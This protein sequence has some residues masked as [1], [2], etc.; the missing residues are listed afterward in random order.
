[1]EFENVGIDI[2]TKISNKFNEDNNEG[3]PSTVTQ[4]LDHLDLDYK[5]ELYE[6]DGESFFCE[7]L[8]NTQEMI[9]DSVNV[10]SVNSNKKIRI[11]VSVDGDEKEITLGENTLVYTWNNK[12]ESPGYIQAKNLNRT[13]RLATKD[14][15]MGNIIHDVTKIEEESELFIVTSRNDDSLS[16]V[17]DG[18]IIIKTK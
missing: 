11:S 8:S 17:L 18:D 2:G 5:N 16:L 3:N 9:F 6:P 15:K 13:H 10:V 12:G 14:N 7:F 1:M 4:L